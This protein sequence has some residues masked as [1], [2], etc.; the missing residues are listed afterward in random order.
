MRLKSIVLIVVISIF[1]LLTDSAYSQ[2]VVEVLTKAREAIKNLKVVKTKGK[3]MSGSVYTI[4]NNGVIDYENRSF[5]IIQSQADKAVSSIYF[6]EETTYMYN[7]MIDSWIKFGED[8]G[9]FANV[10]DKDK[11][12]S[13]FPADYEGTGFKMNIVGEE[14]VEGQLCYVVT[15][16]IVDKALAK[17]FIIKLLD[18]F[19]SEQI[20]DQFSKNPEAK[21]AYVEQYIAS[22]KSTQ[23]I[24]K[25]NFFVMKINDKNEQNDGQGGI[26]ILE[27]ETI[28]Y[29]FNQPAIIELPDEAL[30][31]KLITAGD[32]GVGN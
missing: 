18:S 3:T 25:D 9:M 26:V 31:A 22:A 12:F 23:W 27:N 1:S 30:E 24:S 28:Y 29:D 19:V 6:I 20:V 16:N 7:G 13:F 11:L 4:E 5:S 21:D 32:L 2:D 14:E 15:S 17:K 8:L 10:L